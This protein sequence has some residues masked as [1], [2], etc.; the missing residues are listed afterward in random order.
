VRGIDVT[1][2]GIGVA[3]GVETHATAL[4]IN[5]IETIRSGPLIICFL[6]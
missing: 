2:D 1:V 5:A 4:Q 3:V 6:S